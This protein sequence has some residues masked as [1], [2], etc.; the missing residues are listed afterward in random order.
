MSYE[1][2]PAANVFPMMH[3]S[4]L[5]A[6]AEDIRENGLLN[7]IEIYEGKIIDGRNRYKACELAGVKPDFVE[8]DLGSDFDA[9]TYVLSLNLHRRHLT[10]SQRAMVAVEVEKVYAG[11]A[12]QRQKGGQGGVLLPANLPDAKGDARDKACFP[13]K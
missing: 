8:L 13:F 6:M 3:E 7:A 2:H 11:E 1:N 10:T 12:K 5:R 9:V 4:D